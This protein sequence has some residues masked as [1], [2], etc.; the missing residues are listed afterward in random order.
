MRKYTEKQSFSTS[1]NQKKILKKIS[2]YHN[3][4]KFIRDAI[5][6]KLERENKQPI[7]VEKY[8]YAMKALGG[9]I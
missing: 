7:K 9:N 3:L 8:P 1:E 6:E 5:S 2:K 4:S